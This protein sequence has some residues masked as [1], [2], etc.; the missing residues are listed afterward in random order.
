[1]AKQKQDQ[2]QQAAVLPPVIWRVLVATGLIL[3]VA[4]M[5]IHRHAYFEVEALALFYP[6]LGAGSMALVLIASFIL[7][8][9]LIRPETYYEL[10]HAPKDTGGD[11]A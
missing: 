2:Q 10:R 6:L 9:L 4:D 11:D 3:A 7:K 8:R 1:M 5:L